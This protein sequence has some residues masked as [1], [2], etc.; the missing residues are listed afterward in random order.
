MIV[1]GSPDTQVELLHKHLAK[2]IQHGRSDWRQRCVTG[3]V[4]RSDYLRRQHKL[5][6]KLYGP[7]NAAS[8]EQRKAYELLFGCEGFK[9]RNICL[10]GIPASGKTWI[11]KKLSK[12][13]E[14]VFFQPGEMIRCAPLGRVACTFHPDARTIHSTLH[15]RRNGTGLYPE[16]LV[17]LGKHLDAL[18]QETF[19]NLKVFIASESFMCTGPHLEA[20]LTHIKKANPNCIFLF[21]GDTLQVTTKATAGYPSQPFLTRHAF[22]NVC[23]NTQIIVLEKSTNHRIKNTTKLHHLGLMRLG[24]ATEATVAFF[25]QARITH[26]PRPVL[27]LFANVAP[28]AKFN[29]EKL[30]KTFASNPGATLVTL[31]AKDTLKGTTTKATMTDIEENSL[32][33]DSTI[34]VIKGAPILI[35]QNHIAELLYERDK[36]G[37]KIY[38]G[39]GTTGVFWTFDK[40]LDAVVAKVQLASKEVFVR[41]NRRNF[42]TTT[43]IRSQFPI[44][45]AWAATIHKV[46]GMEFDSLE[47]DFCLDTGNLGQN[48]FYQGLAYMVL[49]R[50]ETVT[51]VGRLTLQLINNVNLQSLAWWK[52]QIEIWNEFK[53][54][55]KATPAKQFRNAIHMHNWHAAAAQGSCKAIVASQK[56]TLALQH[57]D[58]S[59]DA[60]APAPALAPAAGR[61]PLS[62]K[63]VREE[64]VGGASHACARA[65]SHAPAPAPPLAPAPGTRSAPCFSASAAKRPAPAPAPALASAPLRVPLVPFCPVLPKTK[66]RPEAAIPNFVHAYFVPTRKPAMPTLSS[67]FELLSDSKDH[68]KIPTNFRCTA[69]GHLDT[70]GEV[71]P[72]LVNYMMEQYSKLRGIGIEKESTF[73]DLGSG[74]G[75]LVSLIAT[76]RNFQNCFG[77]EFEPKRASFAQP[78]AELFLQKVQAQNM[79][80]SCV[81]IYFGNFLTCDGT[82]RALTTASLIWLNNVKFT[83]INPQILK[84]L[85]TY[86][87]VGCVVVSFESLL[88][89]RPESQESGFKQISEEYVKDAADWTATPQKVYVMQQQRKNRDKR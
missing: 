88:T 82:K 25:K 87:P 50:A 74:H 51:V 33:T 5:R 20:L 18:P 45:L 23:P 7:G 63:R 12:L 46:Q 89:G 47:V 37:H 31:I 77:V 86:V 39:N 69:P 32:P 2:Y 48:E 54:S 57:S 66:P 40:D 19:T 70:Y 30:A 41:I 17:E 55:A 60:S 44:M 79:R 83:D 52:R 85:D 14:C 36:P 24:Q 22:E 3:A 1:T 65:L 34:K 56:L 76:L 42:P 4:W 16:S 13:L 64:G 43:K 59:A 84:L 58:A 78:L 10:V 15:L 8:E 29:D 35:V 73:I 61:E 6:L 49:S 26:R 81:N 27:R 71:T 9:A 28:A 68:L 62:E 11:S 75:G 53:R 38:V 72:N 21:D 80:H 67:L